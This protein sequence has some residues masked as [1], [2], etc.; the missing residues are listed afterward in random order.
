MKVLLVS[1]V[2]VEFEKYRTQSQLFAPFQAQTFWLAGLKSLDCQTRVFRYSDSVLVPAYLNLRITKWSKR[3]L[4]RWYRKY[5]LLKSRLPWLFLDNYFKSISLSW[6]IWRFRPE[7]IVMSGGVSELVGFELILAKHLG[8][9]ITLL[10]GVDPGTA[11]TGYEKRLLNLFDLIVTNSQTHAQAWLKLGAKQAIGLPYSGIDPDY[12]QPEAVDRDI[13]LVFVGTLFSDRIKFLEKLI[14]QGLPIQ[15]YG[16]VPDKIKLTSAIKSVYQG[17]AWGQNLINL[18]SR[19]KIV[20]NPLPDHMPDGGNLRLFEIPAA[21][22]LQLASYCDPDWFEL[23]KEIVVYDSLK[24]LEQKVKHYLR[25][26]KTRQKIA[27]AGQKRVLHDYTYQQRFKQIFF[28][29]YKN[30]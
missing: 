13:D 7:V 15:V 19:A 5:R 24:D 1:Q 4:G 8:V 23:D 9:K 27:K 28:V 30:N 16:F 21:G 10:H 20:L 29:L 11:A 3:H 12:H 14:D 2:P 26:T 25:H 17:E 22:A 6:Q 18:Y